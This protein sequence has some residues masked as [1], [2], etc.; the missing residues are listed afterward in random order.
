MPG[1][2]SPEGFLRQLIRE[3]NWWDRKLK[4]RVLLSTTEGLFK[5]MDG[6][7]KQYDYSMVSRH[8]QG[9]ILEDLKGRG[10][11]QTQIVQ[12]VMRYRP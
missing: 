5:A 9:E 2:R 12:L 3:N 1:K 7:F 4:E 8:E 6:E 10:T 11:L